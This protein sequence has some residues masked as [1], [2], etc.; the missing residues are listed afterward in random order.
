MQKIHEFPKGIF[1]ILMLSLFVII[2]CDDG[3]NNSMPVSTGP[4][5]GADCLDASSN[6]NVLE[7]NMDCLAEAVVDICTGFICE[8]SSTGD[9]G[10]VT[11]RSNLFFAPSNCEATSCLDFSCNGMTTDSSSGMLIEKP[12]F[13]EY[14]LETVS[15]NVITGIVLL[16]DEETSE[17]RELAFSCSPL[18]I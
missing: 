10:P 17:T 11:R 7:E 6:S 16:T 13:G 3:N 4:P 5:P 15:G 18:V 8:I 1:N 12:T 2:G 14:T 9:G